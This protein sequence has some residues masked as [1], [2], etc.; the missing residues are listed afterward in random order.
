MTEPDLEYGSFSRATIR[1]Y[2]QEVLNPVRFITRPKDRFFAIATGYEHWGGV[3]ETGSA[4]VQ[5]R[6]NAIDVPQ[7][8]GSDD[9]RLG[10]FWDGVLR[11][12]TATLARH[13]VS[14][15]DLFGKTTASAM[16][17]GIHLAGGRAWLVQAGDGRVYRVRGELLE[18]C[19]TDGTLG[20]MLVL[21]GRMTEE[22][23]AVFPHRHVVCSLLAAGAEP[24][25]PVRSIDY[26]LGDTF[27]L[28]MGGVNR[29]RKKNTSF[30]DLI[31]DT[32]VDL[33]S[34]ERSV[35]SDIAAEV[36]SK[37]IARDGTYGGVLIVRVGQRGAVGLATKSGGE[38][39]LVP[40]AV[41][42]EREK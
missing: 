11:G 20:E 38:F 1:P 19:S 23:A 24:P 8:A 36:A 39:G 34:T 42:E 6:L 16:L 29:K 26:Q 28:S 33:T 17:S 12:L 2:G 18:Q 40:K 25:P 27:V 13:V 30:H 14:N 37:G 9:G 32:L 21:H 31:E 7:P 3:S 5:E 41:P 10:E 4:I 35:L 15:G 22:E